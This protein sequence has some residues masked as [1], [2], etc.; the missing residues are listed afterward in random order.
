MTP[1]ET[2]E[3]VTLE[4]GG[5]LERLKSTC[6]IV[7]NVR[8]LGMLYAVELVADQATK[9]PLP[10]ACQAAD[11]VRIHGLDNGLLIYSRPTSG[12]RYGDWFTV[13]PP[14]TITEAECDDMLQR[15][16]ATLTAFQ[17]ELTTAGVL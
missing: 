10:A 6:P 17:A 15:L 4:V 1:N 16:E 5:G 7:G 8:G 2:H 12:G 14:L 9:T 13:S 3:P 11:R